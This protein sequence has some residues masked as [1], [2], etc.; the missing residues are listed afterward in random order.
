MPRRRNGLDQSKSLVKQKELLKEEKLI[1]EVTITFNAESSL[2]S[3]RIDHKNKIARFVQP[4]RVVVPLLNKEKPF[5][6]VQN[7]NKTPVSAA[8]KK[9]VVVPINQS[10]DYEP[11]P[12][13]G[14]LGRSQKRSVG[15]KKHCSNISITN[16]FGDQ[17]RMESERE[18]TPLDLP[19]LPIQPNILKSVPISKSLV[20]LLTTRV[21]AVDKQNPLINS[22]FER[23]GKSRNQFMHMPEELDQLDWAGLP[24]PK[25]KEQLDEIMRLFH[26]A[27]HE[28]NV[29]CCVCDQFLRIE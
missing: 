7:P 17:S 18:E 27:V 10:I 8:P 26:A 11:T 19:N 15:A 20:P 16:L 23:R 29:V 1:D 9:S 13:Y 28:R 21:P 5:D 25:T 14:F 24:E 2:G 3:S 22:P 6:N 12:S 4:G